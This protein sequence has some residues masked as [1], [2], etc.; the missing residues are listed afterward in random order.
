MEEAGKHFDPDVAQA[1]LDLESEFEEIRNRMED[2]S[3]KQ[4]EKTG[5]KG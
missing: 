2:V 4:G 5:V 3:E 1:F